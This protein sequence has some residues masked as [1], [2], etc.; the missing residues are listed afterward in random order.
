MLA[1]LT[2]NLTASLTEF[3]ESID[4][5]VSQICEPVLVAG[6][7]LARI[8]PYLREAE[9]LREL[10]DLLAPHG[11][12]VPPSL[13]SGIRLTIRDL[14]IE[15]DA[16]LRAVAELVECCDGE[17]SQQIIACACEC[18]AMKDRGSLLTTSRTLYNRKEGKW[19]ES[20]AKD[21]T[22]SEMML[23]VC[24]CSFSKAI[25]EQL[26]ASVHSET[27]LAAYKRRFPLGFLSRHAVLHGIDKDYG[28]RENST[29]A[30]FV[31]DVL[32][33]LFSSF[34]PRSSS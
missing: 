19:L 10:N 20:L 18:W 7:L 9:S 26:A 12:F 13:D 33:K 15:E 16:P 3:K 2:D 29:K 17:F 14:V 22:L 23:Y 1:N 34:E 27:E 4:R 21:L 31:I 24:L 28:T 8:D 30:L 11:W 5:L 25:P 32:R 6:Q